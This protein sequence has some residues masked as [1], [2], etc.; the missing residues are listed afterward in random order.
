MDYTKA[1]LEVAHAF[2]RTFA[3]PDGMVVLKELERDYFLRNL[4]IPGDPYGSHVNI[5]AHLVV[6]AIHQLIELAH[7]PRLGVHPNTIIEGE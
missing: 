7:D 1:D 3:T 5:G 6:A 4:H 2:K